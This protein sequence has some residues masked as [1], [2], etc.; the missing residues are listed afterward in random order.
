MRKGLARMRINFARLTGLALLVGIAAATPGLAQREQD[1]AY[2][3]AR[4]GQIMQL[5]DII[6]QVSARVGGKCIGSEF[7]AS[8]TLYRLRFMRDGA[9]TNVDVDARTGRIVGKGAF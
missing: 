8:T 3:L 4:D 1:K 2:Q 7:D 5:G 6:A 9:V